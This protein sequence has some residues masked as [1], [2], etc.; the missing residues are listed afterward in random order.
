[1]GNEH[2]L[3]ADVDAQTLIREQSLSMTG[4]GVEGIKIF[5]QNISYP[6]EKKY[7]IFMPQ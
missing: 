4:R 6:I 7:D 2:E 1:M 3:V 5:V